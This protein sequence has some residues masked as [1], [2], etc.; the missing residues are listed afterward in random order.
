MRYYGSELKRIQA[1]TNAEIKKGNI[2]VEQYR[3]PEE[4]SFSFWCRE[5]G[6]KEK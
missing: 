3:V 2:F 4:A 1:K 5:Y 6:H